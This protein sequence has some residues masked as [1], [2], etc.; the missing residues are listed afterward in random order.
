VSGLPAYLDKS[1][2]EELKK[3]SGFPCADATRSRIVG[4]SPARTPGE[5][6]YS[7]LNA[8]CCERIVQSIAGIPLDQFALKNI[9][10][11][12]K[13]TD[14]GFRPVDALRS[15]LVPTTRAAHGRGDGGFLLGQVHDP[16]AAMQ[17]GVSGNAGLFG[18]AADLARFAQMLLNGGEL[19]GVRIL[20][21]ETIA[22]MTR[23]HTQLV[24]PTNGR[25]TARGLLWEIYPPIDGATGADACF[26]FGHT[27]FT[28]TAL[29]IYPEQGVYIIALTNRVHPDEKGGIV[30]F[31]KAVWRTT[32]EQLMA[33]SPPPPASR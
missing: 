1:I 5:M 18:T 28:G 24:T 2:Q 25:P 6:T 8:I 20:K 29:R 10:A 13:M 33:L 15:R 22:E 11:P 26:A 27:G 17:D 19:D 9:F 4:V 32:G 31:R 23:A 3:S 16:L 21:P 30:E 7:C 14:T 12:L